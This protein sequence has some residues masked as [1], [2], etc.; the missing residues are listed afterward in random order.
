MS[1]NGTAFAPLSYLGASS[2]SLS[3]SGGLMTGLAEGSRETCRPFEFVTISTL[4]PDTPRSLTDR[5]GPLGP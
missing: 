1:H 3:I 4:S 5:K 2:K